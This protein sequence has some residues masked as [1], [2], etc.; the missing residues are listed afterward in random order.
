MRTP[1]LVV[2]V[3]VVVALI[4][5]CPLLVPAARAQSAWLDRST[6]KSLHVEFAKPQIDGLD[7][8]FFSFAGFFTA[9]LSAGDGLAF[10]GE[11]PMAR[12]SSDEGLLG[13]ESS[14]MVGNVYLGLESR[15]DEGSGGWFELGVRPPTAGE[16]F[17]FLLG[18]AADVDRWEA[19]FPEVTT[20]RAAGHWRRAPRAGGVGVDLHVAPAVWIP[21][22][23]DTEMFAGYGARVLFAAP[24]ARGGAGLSGRWLATEDEGDFGERSTHQLDAAFDFLRGNVRPGVV[25]RVPLDEDGIFLGSGDAVVGVTVN[26]VLD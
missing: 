11:L 4:A 24:A 6:A 12:L 19:F 22:D 10:V 14:T 8:G 7:E 20:L 2:V 5:A 15:P 16:E 17:A 26:F 23:G 13:E 21:E 1:G 18:A 9:R 3:A 25:L